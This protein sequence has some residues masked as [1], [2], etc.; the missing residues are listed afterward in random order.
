MVFD[1]T[2]VSPTTWIV[3]VDH[4]VDQL[5]LVPGFLLCFRD[6]AFIERSLLC[7]MVRFTAHV[8]S[9]LFSFF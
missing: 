1:D 6:R 8:T 4:T 3:V 9:A 7:P 5:F 2:S